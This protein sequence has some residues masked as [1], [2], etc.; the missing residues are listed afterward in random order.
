MKIQRIIMQFL[1]YAY[2]VKNIQLIFGWCN[3][4]RGVVDK[5][6]H[7]VQYIPQW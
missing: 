5:V 7:H 1:I 4:T 3:F 2:L 6:D